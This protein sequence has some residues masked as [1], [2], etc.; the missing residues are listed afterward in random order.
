MKFLE[1]IIRKTN[2]FQR[3]VGLTIEQFNILAEKLTPFWKKAEDKRKLASARKRK[4]G[5][6][7]PYKLQL[8]QHKILLVLLYYKLYLTQEFLGMVTGIDQANVSRLLKKMLPLIEQAADSELT[9]YLDKIK[10]EHEVAGKISDWVELIKKNPHLRDVSTDV[11]E[12][13]C[14]RSENNEKQKV[15]YSGKKKKHAL[16]TQISVATTGQ[17]LDVSQTY[18]GS[19]HDKAI[20]DQEKTVKKF[21]KQSCLRFDSGYQGIKQE[22]PDYYIVLPTKKPRGK[23]LSDLAKEHNRVNNRRRVIVENVF[24]RLK[25]FRI[26]GNLYRGCPKSYNQIFRNIASLL[27]FKLANPSVIV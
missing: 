5:A 19:V 11:T 2:T 15:H 23:E 1:K 8:L 22:N 3:T 14:F 27:N 21:P 16:K 13:Q 6:G 25:K 20:I 24:S 4:I 9:T 18:P 7:H 10:K 26:C 17:I 12:Q